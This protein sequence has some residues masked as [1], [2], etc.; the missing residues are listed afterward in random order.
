[1]ENPSGSSFWEPWNELRSLHRRKSTG[2]KHRLQQ[3]QSIPVPPSKSPAKPAVSLPQ[4]TPPTPNVT[5][6]HHSPERR[7][8][9]PLPS[10]PQLPSTRF[11][12]STVDRRI[13]HE[14]QASLKARQQQFR[15]LGPPPG[16][17]HAPTGVPYPLSYARGAVDKDCWDDLWVQQLCGSNSWTVWQTP[18]TRV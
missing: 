11:D 14:L 17:P 1:M 13:L 5:P 6:P 3:A 4:P 16:I 8:P 2:S 10:P 9:S 12:M 18:P 7:K 15:H